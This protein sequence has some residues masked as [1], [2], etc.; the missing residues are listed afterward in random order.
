V[1][2]IQTLSPQGGGLRRIGS[3]SDENDFGDPIYC[4]NWHR[5]SYSPDGRRLAWDLLTRPGNEVIAFANADG[6]SV[7]LI[8][9]GAGENDSQPTF[10]PRGDRI[11]YVRGDVGSEGQIVTSNLVGGDVRTVTTTVTG[12]ARVWA[13]NGKTIVFVHNEDIWSVAAGGGVPR[14]IIR[15]GQDPDFSPSGHLLVDLN[16]GGFVQ[17]FGSLFISRADGSHR[18]RVPTSG[19]CCRLVQSVVFSPGGRRLAFGMLSND[20]A[21]KLVV[22]TLPVGGGRPRAIETRSTAFSGGFTDSLSWQPLR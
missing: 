6:H 5:I 15:G 19:K 10:S 22:A 14:R 8:D 13:P 16:N 2:A 11:A 4:E 18:H 21:E 7:H 17:T 20:D 1:A 3:C 12:Y 9:H